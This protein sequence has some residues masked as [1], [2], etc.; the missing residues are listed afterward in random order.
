MIAITRIEEIP[1]AH[2]VFPPSTHPD[3]QHTGA[4]HHGW[5]VGR[6]LLL[7]AVGS[8]LAKPFSGQEHSRRQGA[9]AQLRTLSPL[10]DELAGP[11]TIALHIAALQQPSPG[12]NNDALIPL[13][14]EAL[15]D[16]GDW[17]VR[18]PR[19]DQLDQ[20]AEAVHAL[21]SCMPD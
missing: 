4:V 7:H 6:Q 15:A 21:H 16:L 2:A 10:L 12:T 9:I 17:A 3:L 19:N 8:A 5:N 18:A 11:L 13:I 1:T 20:I 14:G